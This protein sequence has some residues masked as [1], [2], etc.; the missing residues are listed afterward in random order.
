MC[1]VTD[2]R[3]HQVSLIDVAPALDPHSSQN[4]TQWAHAA[5]LWNTVRSENIT[6]NQ[7]VRNFVQ[8][9][10]AD[11]NSL[12]TAD[13]RSDDTASKFALPISGYVFDF[14]AQTVAESSSTFVAN[15]QPSADQLNRVN[16]VAHGAL[17]R[18]YT[19]G[20]YVIL[21][22][23]IGIDGDLSAAAST[24][25]Q[26]A[27]QQYWTSELQRD[28]QSLKTLMSAIASSPIMLPF[29]SVTLPGS[30]SLISL[31]NKSS[32]NPFPPSL[33]CY[34]G[35]VGPQLQLINQ[36]E[37]T[38]FGLP[39]AS[40][41]TAFDASCFPD[42][43]VYGVLDICQLRLPFTENRVGVARQAAV[44]V[45]DVNSRTVVYNGEVASALPG[46][47]SSSSMSTDPQTYGT[48]KSI[49]HVVL[50]LYALAQSTNCQHGGGF[51][52]EQPGSTSRAWRPLV[53][54]SS[55]RNEL[56]YHA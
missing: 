23:V 5:L 26:P 32:P 27:L 35:L 29:D 24:Q 14:A 45:R 17:D 42:R 38:I 39:V 48:M 49:N 56:V 8:L 16:D 19:H 36:L 51:C 43:P 44:L 22:A 25:Q 2:D 41:A 9:E 1:E 4:R 21:L 53:T 31:V 15:C 7:D 54:K 20:R 40:G 33:A 12:P 50:C 52:L 30:A 55:G 6:V 28:A 46:S 37:E 11:W 18:M 10:N 34:P 13:G 3:A 47:S